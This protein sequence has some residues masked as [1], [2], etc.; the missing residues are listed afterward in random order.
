MTIATIRTSDSALRDQQWSRL[1]EATSEFL[2]VQEN[3]Q[4][5]RAAL[6]AA[7]ATL[8]WEWHFLDVDVELCLMLKKR[9]TSRADALQSATNALSSLQSELKSLQTALDDNYEVSYEPV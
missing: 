1:R 5:L 3:V 4:H 2:D 9:I 8:A 6:N 7:R